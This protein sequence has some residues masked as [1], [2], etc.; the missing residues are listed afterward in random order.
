MQSTVRSTSSSMNTL[1]AQRAEHSASRPP[2]RCTV[3]VRHTGG[4]HAHSIDGIGPE[5][6]LLSRHVA[7]HR[8]LEQH[9]RQETNG[10]CAFCRL[11]VS[12]AP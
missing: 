10:S 8:K 9:L 12:A 6:V 5:G 3:C 4:A 7:A 1:R 11:L 2:W